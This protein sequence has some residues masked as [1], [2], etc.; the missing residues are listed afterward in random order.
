MKPQNA[1]PL[2]AAPCA[3]VHEGRPATGRY[4]GSPKKIDWSGLN[5]EFQRSALWRRLHHK[6]WH[7]VAIATERCFI[8][9]AIVDLGWTNTAF[10]Y[11]FDREQ[12]KL[13]ADYSQDGVPGVTARVTNRPARG[14]ASWFKHVG[15]SIRYE[16]IG[17][18][19]YRLA[20]KIQ[21]DLQIDAELDI[22]E[23]ASFLTA[24]GPISDGGCAHATV[25]SSAMAVSGNA[26]AAG[27]SFELNGGVASFDYSNGLLARD[28]QWRWASAHSPAIGFNLQ[29]GYF[30]N[31]E[32]VLWLDGELIPL[33]NAQFAF[34]PEEPLKP[35]HV[36]TDDGLLDLSF[37]PEGARQNRKNLFI[38]ASYYVQPI[39]TFSG[40]VKA[41]PDGVARRIDRLVGVTEDHQSRW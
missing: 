16:H 7:Y 41:S 31:H 24:I 23:A 26:H 28:T 38:A 32:N 10:V 12:K 13:L 33:G 21:R 25:K 3:V 37:Q 19:R 17:E 15:A 27:K 30:G 9:L 40:T 18:S 4:T 35:W 34:D 6:R 2:C 29:Q 5:G 39:G 22:K 14:A 11:V 1:L 20:V 36:S 8:G